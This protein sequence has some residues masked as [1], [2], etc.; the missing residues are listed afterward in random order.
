EARARPLQPMPVVGY[1]LSSVEASFHLNATR[2]RASP[3]G[4]FARAGSTLRSHEARKMFRKRA[5]ISRCCASV[6]RRR[7][8]LLRLPAVA[9]FLLLEPRLTRGFVRGVALLRFGDLARHL[10]EL[11]EVHLAGELERADL[12]PRHVVAV[13]IREVDE[14]LEVVVRELLLRRVVRVD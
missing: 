7:L 2:P 1:E 4:M 5:G 11:R 3:E 10:F 9:L 8:L 12:A 6:R 13:V 14:E